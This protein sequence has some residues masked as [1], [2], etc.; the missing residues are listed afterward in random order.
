MNLTW[1]LEASARG[2]GDKPALVSDLGSM[3][4][5]ELLAASTRAAAVL[6]ERGVGPGDRVGV[7][8]YNTPA[9]AVAA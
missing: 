1:M 5:A 4:Y 6:R 2:C 3:T 9:F 7:M 8:T